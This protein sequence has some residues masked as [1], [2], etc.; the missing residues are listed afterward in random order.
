ME[1][2]HN[3]TLDPTAANESVLDVNTAE[4]ADQKTHKRLFQKGA[5]C[6]LIGVLL[7][8]AS[9]ALNFLLFHGGGDFSV[10]MYAMTSV[11]A[12][13]LMAGMVCILGF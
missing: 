13:L 5:L 2:L 3:T 7:L 8:G 6:I 1:S 10:P 9:L 11:G 4:T 12:L